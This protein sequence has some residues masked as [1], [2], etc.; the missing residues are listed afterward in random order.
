MKLE[1]ILKNFLDEQFRL[2]AFPTK[3]KM[4]N[5]ALHYL[6]SKFD[7]ER[8]YTEKE[9][10]E[11]LNHWHTF[12]DAALLRRELFDR[13]YLDRESN[14]SKYWMEAEQPKFPEIENF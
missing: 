13:G 1:Q 8:L 2:K 4:Q 11:L 3:Q 7:K 10:N 9:V 14:G 6:A 5:Y 12:H